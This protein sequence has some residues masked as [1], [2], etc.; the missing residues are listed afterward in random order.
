MNNMAEEPSVA[1]SAEKRKARLHPLVFVQLADS[2]VTLLDN[3]PTQTWTPEE[4]FSQVGID[5]RWLGYRILR[6]LHIGGRI[7]HPR[8]GRYQSVLAILA[9]AQLVSN[10]LDCGPTELAANSTSTP[11]ME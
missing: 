3:T 1:P 11:S 9:T 7:A 6:R 5:D 10:G 8:W 4:I 2:V